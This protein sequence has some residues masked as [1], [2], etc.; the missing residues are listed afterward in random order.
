M[1]PSSKETQ[2]VDDR[3]IEL[4]SKGKSFASIA[5]LIG[6]DHSVDVFRMF[7]AEL[8]RRPPAEQ[9][10]LRAEENARLDALE[11]RTRD[12]PDPAERERKLASI[13]KL[14]RRLVAPA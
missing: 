13:K 4:R 5:K 9:T 12:N 14:R 7:V 10:K 2:R 8:S 3:V 6:A 11:R 1:P